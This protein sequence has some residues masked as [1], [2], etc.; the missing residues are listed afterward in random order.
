MQP[1]EG[2]RRMWIVI[3]VVAAVVILAGV[4]FLPQLLH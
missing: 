4:C 1:D 2:K 3:V